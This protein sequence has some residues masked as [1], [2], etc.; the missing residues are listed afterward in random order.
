MR[1]LHILHDS[2]EYIFVGHPSCDNKI[3][4]PA[5]STHYYKS[6]LF[7]NNTFISLCYIYTHANLASREDL[8]SDQPLNT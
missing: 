4:Y 3:T 8:L 6:S 1:L 2:N 5:K 7:H